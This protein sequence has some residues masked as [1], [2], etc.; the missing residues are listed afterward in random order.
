MLGKKERGGVFEKG[1]W[2]S[3]G[4]YVTTR[5]IKSLKKGKKPWGYYHLMHV[6]CKWQSNDLSLPRY[7]VRQ[8]EFFVN[9]DPFLYFYLPPSPCPPPTPIS[10]PIVTTWKS[11]FWKKWKTPRDIIILHMCTINENH[12]VYGSWYMECNGHNFLS[13][14]TI[15]ALLPN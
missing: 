8:T 4:H 12:M 14:W 5:K 10:P 11:N 1:G 6:Y 2:Y 9:F 3:N 15:F 7:E 13:F